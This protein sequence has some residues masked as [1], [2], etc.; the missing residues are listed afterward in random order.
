M[1]FTLGHV[2]E[3]LS[4]LKFF[5][6][7]FGMD[8]LVGKL[9][10]LP[11][12][13][14]KTFSYDGEVDAFLRQYYKPDA[15]SQRFFQPF[16][17]SH[18]SNRWLSPR[19]PS[20]SSQAT[21]T[22]G[23]LKDSFIHSKDTDKWGWS[24]GYVGVLGRKLERDKKGKVPAYWLAVWLFRSRNWPETTT[25][26]LVVKSF[27]DEFHLTE[28]EGEELF[29]L[30]APDETAG[31][32][33]TDDP[34]SDKQLLKIIG[35]PPGAP[36]EEGG[37]LNFLELAGMGPSRT[38]TL[39]PSERMTIVT[40]DNGLGKTFLLE[41][42][43]WSLT[44]QWAERPALPRLDAG[45]TEPRITFEISGR[46]STSKKTT[47]AFDWASQSWPVPRGRP[48][49]PGIVVYARVDGSFAIWDPC[50]TPSVARP[51][52]SQHRSRR[53]VPLQGCGIGRP[54]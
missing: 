39:N 19:Y 10:N 33:F 16:G 22:K 35:R 41:C 52:R 49:I 18:R 37:I 54:A 13:K 50:E 29:D 46:G 34:Y 6:P 32:V 38:L 51:W 2:N 8:F 36:P 48:T 17:P 31:R 14:T 53:C 1:Y 9:G 42:A 47:I 30:S 28:R 23:D 5:H 4:H 7:F 26:P 12:G 3:S 24:N 25:S 40:G 20:T 15:H 11:V 21:R 45:R 44:G 43:W 27:T